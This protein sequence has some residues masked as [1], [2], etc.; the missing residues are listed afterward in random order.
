M[1]ILSFL[2]AL[3]IAFPVLGQR[4]KS[5]T[6]EIPPVVVF[7]G[8][9]YSLPRTVISITV[10]TKLTVFV[11]GPFALYGESLLG[12]RDIK[13]KDEN[14]WEMEKISI[15]TYAE[16]DPGQTYKTATGQSSSIQLTSDGCLAG[17]NSKSPS[18]KFIPDN[19]NS[20]V[21]K[22]IKEKLVF[23]YMIDNPVVSGRTPVEQMASEAAG[24]ILKARSQRYEIAAGM[25]DE[26]HP[27]GKA[28]EE[29]L[30]ELRRIEED[31]LDLF[32]GKSSSEKY[33]YTFT[34]VPGTN[35]VKGEVLVRFDENLGILAKNDF[36]GSAI[37]LD[38]EKDNSFKDSFSDPAKDLLSGSDK[39][40]IYYRQPGMGNIRLVRELTLIATSRVVIAQFGYIKQLPADMLNGNYIVEFHPESG[41]L[42]SIL[43]K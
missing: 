29:S 40:G 28:Y 26:F 36:S 1:K 14:R 10:H 15:S 42:K 16:A 31:N 37:T 25:L 9:I 5:K 3:L 8:V 33:S 32:V 43:P 18:G 6:E 2:C 30:K 23:P 21:V 20:L 19:T 11:P 17:I 13:T 35:D 24:R 41:A 27:D 39:T 7:D 12:I 22:N 34:F 38:I 4:S